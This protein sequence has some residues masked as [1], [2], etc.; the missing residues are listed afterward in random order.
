MF[1]GK[2]RG[3]GGGVREDGR[4]RGGGGRR[5]ILKSLTGAG[6]HTYLGEPE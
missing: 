6:I 2:G 3:G 1:C 5:E 4:G